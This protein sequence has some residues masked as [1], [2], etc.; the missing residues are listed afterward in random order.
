M[1]RLNLV[2]VV[3]VV[4][5]WELDLCE[6]DLCEPVVHT[7]VNNFLERSIQ[8]NNFQELYHLLWIHL[9]RDLLQVDIMNPFLLINLDT[10][11]QV[12]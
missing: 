5:L 10:V 9:L 7:L 8:V 11:I 3:R 6:L 2:V 12:I 4:V 1:Q